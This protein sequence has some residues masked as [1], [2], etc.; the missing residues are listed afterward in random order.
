MVE[1]TMNVSKVVEEFGA[2]ITVHICLAVLQ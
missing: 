2:L 1:L